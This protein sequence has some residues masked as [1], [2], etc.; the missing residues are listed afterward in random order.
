MSAGNLAE[1]LQLFRLRADRGAHFGKTMD[2][3]SRNG[4]RKNMK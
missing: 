2:N 1:T 3:F 4:F